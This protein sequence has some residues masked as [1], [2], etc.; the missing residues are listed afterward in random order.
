M[1]GTLVIF[2][3]VAF[4]LL[5]GAIPS[6]A[7]PYLPAVKNI[8]IRP[9]LGKENV[10]IIRL[11]GETFASGKFQKQHSLNGIWKFKGLDYQAK[12]FGKMK[13]QEKNLMAETLDDSAWSKIE[14]PLNWWLNPETSYSK[15]PF[16]SQPY[17]RG[18]YRKEFDLPEISPDRSYTLHFDNIGYEA[19]IFVNGKHAGSHHGDFVPYDQD[20]TSLLKPGRNLVALRVLADQGP[21]KDMPFTRTYGAR[22]VPR[23]IKGGIWHNV[24]LKESAKFVI[25]RMLLDPAETRDRI[26]VRFRINNPTPETVEVDVSGA[27]QSDVPGT[28]VPRA[29]SLGKFTLKS[30]INDLEAVIPYPG[31]AKLWSID[32]PNLYYVILVAEKEN[33]IVASRQE[34]TGFRTMKVK[35]TGF[36]FNNKPI[37]L[38]GESCHSSSHGGLGSKYNYMQGLQ[39]LVTRH[40]ANGIMMLRTAHM[41]MIQEFYDLADEIGLMVYDEWG[42][43]FVNAIDKKQFEKN[44]LAELEKFIVRD[45]NHPSVVLWSLGNENKHG[46]HPEIAAQID[47]QYDLLKKIDHQ[48]RPASAF[49]GVSNVDGFGRNKLKT[50]FLDIHHYQGMIDSSWVK[51]YPNFDL[52]YKWNT[53]IYGVN[54]KLN[55]PIIMW[56]CV[57]AGWGHKYDKSFKLNHADNYLLHINKPMNWGIPGAN[58]YSGA[59]GLAAALDPSRGKHYIQSYLASR[60]SEIYRQDKRLAGFGPWFSDYNVPE[61]TR[62]S[63]PVLGGLRLNSGKDNFLMPRQLALPSA[64]KLECFVLNQS[65]D[66]LAD[67]KVRIDLFCNGKTT[68]LANVKLGKISA[69][70]DAAEKITL[71]LPAGKSAVG[72]IRLT[73][74][75]GQKEIGRNYYRVKLHNAREIS[76]P[77]SKA[78]TVALIGRNPALEK[79]LKDLQ[80]PFVFADAGS[81]Y[82]WKCA[83]VAPGTG[84]IDHKKLLNFAKMGGSLL[85]LEPAKG[86]LP[87]LTDFTVEAAGNH[88]TD[89]VIPAH[90][91]FAGLTQAD[92]ELWAENPYG[93]T[94]S[95]ALTPANNGVLAMK[96]LYILRK[97][98]S[99]GVAEYSIGKGRAIISTLN[100][101]AVW[102]INPAASRY[103]RNLLAYL[104]V[105][106]KKYD[107]ETY[108][109]SSP[110]TFRVDA[111]K[112][113][114]LDLKPFMNRSFRD[115]VAE[116]G[117]GGWTDQGDNDFRM[118]PLGQQVFADIPFNIVDPAENNGKSCI[119]LRARYCRNFPTSIKNI[120]VNDFISAFYA[121]QTSAW[122]ATTSCATYRL[123]YADGTS[124]DYDLRCGRDIGDWWNPGDMGNAIAVCKHTNSRGGTVGWYVSRIINPYPQKKI[125][126]MDIYSAGYANGDADYITPNGALPII[127]AITAEKAHHDPLDILSATAKP[128]KVR[129]TTERLRPGEKNAVNAD[130]K[131]SKKGN[132]IAVHFPQ[133]RGD[134]RPV[135]LV[136]FDT[137]KLKSNSYRFF[138]LTYKSNHR[139]KI[140]MRISEKSNKLGLLHSFELGNSEGTPVTLRLDLASDFRRLQ[141]KPFPLSDAR[142]EILFFDDAKQVSGVLRDPVSFEILEMRFE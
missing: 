17:F 88:L 80:I 67:V 69:V 121:L 128:I 137:A 42:M 141:N 99:M 117:K 140:L 79:V 91:V 132:R 97:T 103:L 19:E 95:R 139:R 108:Q 64:R 40:K 21:G 87:V 124:Y 47:K 84:K 131:S 119:M 29:V 4:S 20:I 49:S 82:N 98:P 10:S 36:L 109:E 3:A 51:W 89:L 57:G 16:K 15:V 71:T 136:F 138:T 43:C 28:E 32:D 104:A 52:Y 123:N 22:W 118:M 41:P 33:K 83:I 116:D 76:S 27:I 2:S 96:P 78:Q 25:S 115:D 110:L 133:I 93:E 59:V 70:S 105:P 38:I 94:I 31:K 61:I 107:A 111:D 45:Y 72:E 75:D 142:G 106:G 77:V 63:Q 62:W 56:E 53:E 54:G 48:N 46:G 7:A 24:S 12:P 58:G 135:V 74:F 8:Q 102:N 34:R 60:L 125:R 26:K 120:R 127:A 66:P 1:K 122:V 130:L 37:Y 126:S 92:F 112:L 90:P 114:Q 5:T 81:V 9:R 13:P 6:V 100:T 14:V 30:G 50:D 134:R 11:N 55:L 113:V 86:K 18:Y 35:D 68:C 44:N 129:S 23:C 73:V 101:L 39:L 85:I 65:S